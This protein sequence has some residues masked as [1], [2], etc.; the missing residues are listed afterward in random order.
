MC[1]K[2]YRPLTWP[3]LEHA[4]KRNFGGLEPDTW[5]PYGEFTRQIK[6]NRKPPDLAN[7]AEEVCLVYDIEP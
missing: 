1:Q 3:Q 7:I 5:S 6:V 2:T 4:I